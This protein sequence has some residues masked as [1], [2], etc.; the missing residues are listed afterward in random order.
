M[1]ILKLVPSEYA[2]VAVNCWVCPT[3]MLGFVG[4]TEMD[5][6]VAAVTVRLVVPKILPAKALMVTVP[7]ERGV[8]RPLLL[9]ITT[10]VFEECQVT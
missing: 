9:T 4:D 2:P 10:A 6:R 8:T 3:V 5:N 7:G 1:V